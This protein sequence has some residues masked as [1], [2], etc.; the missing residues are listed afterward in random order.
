MPTRLQ[1]PTQLTNGSRKSL[2]WAGSEGTCF[3]SQR[4]PQPDPPPPPTHLPPHSAFSDNALL[5]PPSKK[6]PHVHIHLPPYLLGFFHLHGNYRDLRW[7]YLFIL[8]LIIFSHQNASLKRLE[9]CSVLFSLV[10]SAPRRPASGTELL[11]G[12]SLLCEWVNEGTEDQ[13]NCPI[14]KNR[15]SLHTEGGRR[16][17]LIPAGKV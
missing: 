8:L 3:S 15:S 4:P 5:I 7:W 1:L 9:T 2:Q 14:P 10:S 16:W 17:S 11:L 12:C 6:H 13:L